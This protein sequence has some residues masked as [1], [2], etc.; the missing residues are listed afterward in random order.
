MPWYETPAFRGYWGNH[1]TGFNNEANP[2][3][4]GPDGQRNIWSNYYPIIEPYDS[5]DPHTLECHML[6]MKL[7]GI[8]GVIADWYGISSAADYPIIQVATEAALRRR[9]RV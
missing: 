8:D 4:I 7:A 9:R 2:N 5:A 1:W 3:Q 6:Q